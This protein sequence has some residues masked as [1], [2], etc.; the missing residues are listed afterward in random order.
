LTEPLLWAKRGEATRAERHVQQALG[1]LKSVSHVHH[2]RHYL[3]AALAT[4]GETERAIDQL[5]EAAETG[6]P[7]YPL[8]LSD[9]HL[10]AIRDHPNGTKLLA[11]LQSGWQV[12]RREFGKRDG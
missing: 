8:F 2:T 11:Q 6:F 10:S 12:L 9:P 7:N 4:M 3:A 1:N 5:R